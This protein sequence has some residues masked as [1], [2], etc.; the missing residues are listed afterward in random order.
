M[1]SEQ[2]PL[3]QLLVKEVLNRLGSDPHNMCSY[4]HIKPTSRLLYNPPFDFFRETGM[5]IRT[6]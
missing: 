1:A 4:E 5:W 3:N 2:A 6:L